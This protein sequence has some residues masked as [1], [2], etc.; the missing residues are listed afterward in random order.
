VAVADTVEILPT[1]AA[2]GAQPMPYPN[3]Q[4]TGID[5]GQIR[6]TADGVNEIRKD[7]TSVVSFTVDSEPT[8]NQAQNDF[9]L[10]H[11]P[12]ALDEYDQTIQKTDKQWLKDYCLPRLVQVAD[13]VG[14]FDKSS[15]GYL[16]LILTQPDIATKYRPTVP[17]AGSD[18]LDA[19]AQAAR[20]AADTAN[21]THQ[22]LW[23]ILSF[24][25][26]IDKSRGDNAGMGDVARRLKDSGADLSDPSTAGALADAR[27]A[28][29]RDAIDKKQFKQAITLI[30]S[31]KSQFTDPA[32]QADALY[33]IAQARQGQ[34]Q[35]GQTAVQLRDAAIAYVRVVAD[36]KNA[37]GAPHV[38]DSLLAAAAI[39]EK[40]A[41]P[42]EAT[43]LY[44]SVAQDYPN[45]PAAA[46]AQKNLQR[47]KG[48]LR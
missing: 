32:R 40:L 38:T 8:F 47:L 36:F 22:Q 2:A 42:Q 13:K 29:A 46:E 1:G 31:A 39:L 9:S 26:D 45:T 19:A 16:Q 18:T 21:I 37:P 20:T 35:N 34:A 33:L 43:Q 44:Q 3:V 15:Q 5:N 27:L 11:L 28:D 30:D 14:R 17:P 10:N 41:E 23:A 24:W 6:F 25:M 48:S 7:L 12:R 4:I